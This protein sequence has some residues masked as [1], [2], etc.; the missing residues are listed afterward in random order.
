MTRQPHSVG[1]NGFSFGCV[2]FR[3]MVGDLKATH[4]CSEASSV[5]FFPL[6]HTSSVMGF[7]PKE[8]RMPVSIKVVHNKEVETVSRDTGF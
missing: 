8:I 3:G 2:P 6:L 1:T 7:R 5:V 4:S